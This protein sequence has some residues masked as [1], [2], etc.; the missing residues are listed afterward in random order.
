VKKEIII[1]TGYLDPQLETTTGNWFSN[2]GDFT[3]SVAKAVRQA[4]APDTSDYIESYATNNDIIEYNLNSF[5]VSEVTQLKVWVYYSNE[6]T[7]TDLYGNVY[8]N[9]AW[10]T[11]S[12]FADS[13]SNSW[14]SV[15][16][17]GSWPSLS[18]CKLRLKATQVD[19]SGDPGLVDVYAAYVEITYTLDPATSISLTGP[20]TGR[21]SLP[22]RNFTVSL[23]GSNSGLTVT[24]SDGGDGGTFA[25]TTVSL[26]TS[27]LTATF[28]YIAASSGI[29]TISITNSGGLTNPS[30]LNYTAGTCGS[31]FSESFDS[32]LP[33]GITSS[34]VT[35]NSTDHCLSSSGGGSYFYF[36][37][38][39]VSGNFIFQT[40]IKITRTAREIVNIG[41]WINSSG[42]SANGFL[43][44]IQTASADG[45]FFLLSG[46]SN[47]SID[48]SFEAVTANIWYTV[49]IQAVG[50][51]VTATVNKTSDNSL[52][53]NLTQ[54][55]TSYIDGTHPTSGTFG[56]AADG[57]GA[58]GG[59]LWDNIQVCGTPATIGG[60]AAKNGSCFF[61]F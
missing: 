32:A 18:G 15:T 10:Q 14:K 21:A 3:V 54:D 48:A 47:S 57:A 53:G 19:E 26:S 22:S 25:P 34:S 23:N 16:F 37:D 46:G 43:F 7:K 41:F 1:S 55:L 60:N 52:V 35:Y 24:P 8:I 40:D 11:D 29:K 42:A 27:T 61:C 33:S 56:Q 28:K 2:F 17:T 6:T 58:A 4:T 20:S 30:N 51:I 59:Q 50:N 13:G 49:T 31:T 38:W 9:G 44:R 12:Q 36:D 45:G 5:L 39:S